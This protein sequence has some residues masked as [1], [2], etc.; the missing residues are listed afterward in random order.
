MTIAIVLR[1]HGVPRR[2]VPR[3]SPS[4]LPVQAR[5]GS[6]RPRWASTS[7]TCMCGRAVPDAARS[8]GSRASRAWAWWR[9]SGR[10]CRTRAP[11]GRRARGLVAPQYGAYAG[12]LLPADQAIGLPETLDDV[13]AAS[14]LLKALT[15]DML[16]R[17][18]HR[19]TAG[20]TVLV[21]AAAGGVGRLLI[22][23][24]ATLG[25]TVIGTAGSE[26][27]AA[28]AVAAGAS[29]RDP[30]PRAGRRGG[31]APAH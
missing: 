9:R 11:R 6:A 28:I 3:R 20:E 10:G 18:V 25:A 31:G 1:T 16:L 4:A 7:T 14:F 5:S 22:Q 12:A 21:H 30:V 29:P 8:R 2:C 24:A 17:Q 27:K 19:V 15:A 26:E 23:W 13:A